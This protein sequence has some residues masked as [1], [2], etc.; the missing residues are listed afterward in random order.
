MR[1][2][3]VRSDSGLMTLRAKRFFRPLAAAALGACCGSL[4]SLYPVLRTVPEPPVIA[5]VPRTSG[6]AYTEDMRRGAE[7]AA[8]SAG[9]QIYW[10][11]PAREDDVDRQ[12][13]IA[14]EAVRRGAKAL[15]LGP[16]NPWGV[17]TMVNQLTAQRLPV[18]FVQT[19][20]VEPS[21]P[22]LTW[23]TPNQEEFGRLAAA[24]VAA[25]A[26][27][28]PVAIVGIDRQTPETLFRADGF[29]HAMAAWPGF[30]IV[31]ESPGAVQTLEAEQNTR[32]LVNSYPDLKAIFAVSA[33]A[34]QGALLALKDVD[35]HHAIALIASDRDLFLIDGLR[36][37]TL[38]ALVSCNG[39]RIGYL[40]VQAALEGIKSGHLPRP[41]YLDPEL[42]T[43]DHQSFHD[44][45]NLISA[46]QP[47]S[48]SNE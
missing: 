37:A 42:L 1:G 18:V 46:T 21:G 25:I 26:G 38:N 44:E 19:D 30:K 20:P 8:R 3:M 31:A 2:V 47:G 11:A 27:D 23:V 36:Q 5:F 17:T 13:R 10:N 40:A 7:A 24:R 48:G 39:E 43:S 15:I 12:I 45:T 33:D 9:Y 41:Q 16:A 29:V 32:E 35:P 6:T 4:V 14:Q 22:Y 34:A 28:G